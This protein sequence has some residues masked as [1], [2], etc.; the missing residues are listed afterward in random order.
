MAEIGAVAENV[1]LVEIKVCERLC[2]LPVL[3]RRK[4]KIL[5]GG[6]QV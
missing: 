3:F 4:E 5:S 1:I 2:R 6:F